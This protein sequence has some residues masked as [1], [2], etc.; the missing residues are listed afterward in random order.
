MKRPLAV[1]FMFLVSVAATRA[2][3][4]TIFTFD[5]V[6]PVEYVQIQNGYGGLD[7]QNF[8]IQNAANTPPFDIG[9]VSSPN[10]AFNGLG[11]PASISSGNTFTLQSAYLTAAYVNVEQ[12]RVQGFTQGIQ[13]YDNTY[14]INDNA[15]TLVNFNYVGVDQVSFTAL[16]PLSTD[17]FAMDNMVIAVPEPNP[18][19]LML[20]CTALG[21]F[22][23]LGRKAG[24]GERA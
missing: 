12:I 8:F 1:F 22:V 19:A 7:W 23:V 15:P 11:D 17:I 2:D 9:M 21:M 3:G 4:P 6:S 16:A 13:T 18:C 20:L 14:T 5:N 10:V 24:I